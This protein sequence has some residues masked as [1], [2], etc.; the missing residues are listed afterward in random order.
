[1]LARKKREEQA[2]NRPTLTAIAVAVLCL[3]T[4]AGLALEKRPIDKVDTDELI[5]NT[6]TK[7][8][9]GHRHVSIIWWIPPEFWEA[10]FA[11]DQNTSEAGKK[12]MIAALKPYS[13]LAVLQADIS[14][15]GVFTFYDKEEVETGLKIRFRPADGEPYQIT[16][17]KNA[18]PDVKMLLSVIKPILTAAMGNL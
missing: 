2:M 10:T 3:L 11:K 15:F 4:S 8:P 17:S 16:P 12:R 14:D 7:V 9:S 6:Q 13:L 5:K 1:M 18:S